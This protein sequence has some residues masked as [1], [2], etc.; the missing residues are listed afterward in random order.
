MSAFKSIAPNQAVP[1]R[2]REV[3]SALLVLLALCSCA[4][5][6][7]AKDLTGMWESVPTAAQAGATSAS[8]CF[9]KDG[10]V[11][12]I[13]QVQGRTHRVRGTYKLAGN[14]LTI[15]SSDLDAPATLRTSLSLG[16]L[17]LTSPS[18]ST[19]KYGKVAASC[20]DDGR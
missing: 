10:S 5:V 18:G 2:R 6:P 15:E 7:T 4:S 20:D 9:G 8:Y 13:S 12:W 11:E 17:E 14:V 1:T 19:L 3:A 16:K